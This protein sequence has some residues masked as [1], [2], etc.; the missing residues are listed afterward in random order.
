MPQRLS[1]RRFLQST[2]AAA[3]ALWGG[4]V[5]VAADREKKLPASERLQVGVVGTTNQAEYDLNNVHAGGADIVALC[6]VDER[7]AA[8]TRSR[9]PK[10][11]FF[12]DYRRLVEHKG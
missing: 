11:A 4:N 10:A 7:R 9:F 3:G 8:G 5:L 6:D 12:T 1:R 2:A